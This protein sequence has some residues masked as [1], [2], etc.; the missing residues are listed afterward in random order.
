MEFELLDQNA[1]FERWCGDRVHQ[2]SKIK[3]RVRLNS[4]T[5]QNYG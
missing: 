2:S 5:F 3:V 4:K 1:D